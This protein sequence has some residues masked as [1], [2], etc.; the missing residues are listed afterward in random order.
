MHGWHVIKSWSTT[1][2]IVAMSSAEAELYAMTKGAAHTLG[3][4]SLGGDFGMNLNAKVHTD[5]SAAL[6]IVN[7]QGLGKLRHIRVQYLWLQG[8]V[9]ARDIEVGKVPGRDNPA[10]LLTKHLA[11][12]DLQRHLTRLCVEVRADRAGSAPELNK[13]NE[14]VDDA[15][16]YNDLDDW[17][18]LDHS[19]VRR[20]G[21]PRRSLFTPLRVE[22][23][24]PV[25]ALTPVRITEGKYCDNGEAFRRTDSWTTRST[26]H[27]SM[28]R[29]WTGTTTF[30]LRSQERSSKEDV[31]EL[32]NTPV[33]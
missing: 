33:L 23:S 6:G 18:H 14:I 9:K 21:R 29:R 30:L 28:P 16:R 1:Q 12:H 4:M 17:K 25:K 7:R 2:A 22:G 26:S 8:R 27:L 31:Q 20:H 11:A 15:D 13:V 5:A 32:S 3:I 24:P 19:L 10:D